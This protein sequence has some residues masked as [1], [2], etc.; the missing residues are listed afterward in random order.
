MG[1]QKK[2]RQLILRILV[3]LQI[4]RGIHQ[5]SAGSLV[6]RI[7]LHDLSKRKRG[8][9]VL[10]PIEK[11]PRQPFCHPCVIR[12]Q[13]QIFAEMVDRFRGST[14]LLGPIGLPQEGARM[15]MN[16]VRVER[17][18]RAAAHACGQY[19]TTEQSRV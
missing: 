2:R 13:E 5:K 15:S 6:L 17:V 16:L 12:G 18:D 10:A 1:M 11:E 19:K 7:A 9:V 3:S 8:F 4:Q 14:G